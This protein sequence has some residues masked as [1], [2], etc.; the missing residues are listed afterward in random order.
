LNPDPI[1]HIYFC[2]MVFLFGR[3]LGSDNNVDGHDWTM[4][5]ITVSRV[6]GN[7]FQE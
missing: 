2:H 5:K 1:P 7:C 6:W 3:I 4:L